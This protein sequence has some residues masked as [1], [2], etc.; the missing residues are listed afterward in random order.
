MARARIVLKGSHQIQFHNLFSQT[1]EPIGA[2]RSDSEILD[3][4][5]AFLR[6]Q[7]VERHV[8]FPYVYEKIADKWEDIPQA[9]KD[10]KPGKIWGDYAVDVGVHVKNQRLPGGYH[11]TVD[12]VG[13]AV[14]VHYDA[15]DP[16]KGLVDIIY[17]VL[18]DMGRYSSSNLT[19][20]Q[21]VG[22]SNHFR[23]LMSQSD[24]EP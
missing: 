10:F 4:F 11:I 3:E 24:I 22:S 12:E 13:G 20:N 6:I 14:Y 23:R 7:G 18:Y 1:D 19:T 15:F 17:H 8:D 2:E 21:V 5:L 16:S 9:A